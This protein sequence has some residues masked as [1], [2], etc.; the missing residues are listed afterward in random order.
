MYREAIE[1]YRQGIR[2]E[3]H[4]AIAHCLLGNAYFLLGMDRE[5]IEAFNQAIRIKPDYVMAHSSLGFTYLIIG[6][7]GMALEQY[8]ILK[9]LD[10]EKA[11]E[12][13]KMI[14]K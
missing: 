5:V 10:P 14:Y 3:P 1:A 13:F 11:E 12:L 2:I 7:R 9:E 8:K 4:D 6:N